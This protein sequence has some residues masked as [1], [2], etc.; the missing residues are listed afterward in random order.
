[1]SK[2]TKNEVE[3][4]IADLEEGLQV[5]LLKSNIAPDDRPSEDEIRR[6]SYEVYLARNG[7]DGD[8]LSDWLTAERELRECARLGGACGQTPGIVGKVLP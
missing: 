5:R 7:G 4:T 6:R 2:R 1:M 8:P 3:R